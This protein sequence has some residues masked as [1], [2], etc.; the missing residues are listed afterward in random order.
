MKSVQKRIMLTMCVLVVVSLLIVSGTAVYLNMQTTNGT[1]EQTM[2][3]MAEIASKQVSNHLRVYRVI[4]EG[5]ASDEAVWNPSAP[6]EEK[7]AVLDEIS[8]TYADITRGNILG[9]DGTS[10]FTGDSF[11][12]RE[13]YKMAMQGQTWVSDPVVSKVTGAVSI[14]IAAP[15]WQDGIYGSTVTGVIYLVPTE[16]FLND[17]IT[18]I[19]ISPGA[20]AQIINKQGTVIAHPNMDFVA[21]ASNAQENEKT[22][23]AIV[24]IAAL[25]RE[26]MAGKTGFGTYSM[27]GVEK[28]LGYAPIEDSNGWSIGVNAP[29]SDFMS[30]T[31]TSVIITVILLTVAVI[32][33]LI[34]SVKLANGIG[35]PLHTLADIISSIA[36]TGRVNIGESATQQIR[37][38]CEIK[39][40]IG[41]LANSSFSLIRMLE[42]KVDN[43]TAISNGDLTVDVTLGSED[44]AIGN[45]LIKMVDSLNDM[46]SNIDSATTQVAT[47]SSQI[48]DGAQILAQGA[49]EQAATIQELSASITEISG[50]TRHNAEL[51]NEAKEL[52]DG[53][54]QSADQGSQQ[55]ENMIQAVNEISEAG[56][57]IGKVIKIIDDIAF[58]T[59]ILALNAAVEAARA[60]QHGKGFAVVADEVRNLAAKSADAAK[61]TS[62]LI[63]MSIAK[64]ETGAKISN[65]TAASLTQ[66]IQGILRSSELVSEIS[67]LSSEQA[68]AI[69][70]VGYGVEQVSQVVQQNSA[71]SE[72]NAAASEEMS[73]QA[74]LLQQL[75][76]QFKIKHTDKHIAKIDDSVA[77]HPKAPTETGFTMDDGKY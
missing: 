52:G 2:V 28:F 35:K 42:S 9:I 57:S 20:G 3:K 5:A 71:T 59:N 17:M 61:N 44:D 23:P 4:A 68:A 18:E 36:N 77:F 73:G 43:L 62:E 29:L 55:M 48:A 34:A 41:T 32:I 37:S 58:Q 53:I 25:E 22:D 7:Q 74:D 45:A 47:G 46:F 33:T 49:T 16:T 19:K 70:Q 30:Y 63:E 8:N 54:R 15:I 38:Y 51:A 6:L 69:S 24:P 50:Q 64:S 1:L 27:L 65:E 40:E 66:I 60:G 67:K 11:S 31:V 75:M 72:Q 13:Y 76:S 56:R 26:M 39:D 10:I 21:N 12:D 14:I